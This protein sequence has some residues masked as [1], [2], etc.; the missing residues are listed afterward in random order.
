[1]FFSTFVIPAPVVCV[2]SKIITFEFYTL[3]HKFNSKSYSSKM[4][5]LYAS[6]M[7]NDGRNFNELKEKRE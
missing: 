4:R 5:A 7:E 3:E 2:S 6:L 1:M